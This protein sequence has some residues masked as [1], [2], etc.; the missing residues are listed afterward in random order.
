MEVR[1]SG[2]EEAAGDGELTLSPVEV[3]ADSCTSDPRQL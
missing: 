3:Y 2:R 1:T